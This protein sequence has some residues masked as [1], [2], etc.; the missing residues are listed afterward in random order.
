MRFHTVYFVTYSYL[1]SDSEQ[2][3]LQRFHIYILHSLHTAAA[4]TK[5]TEAM[6]A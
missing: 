5:R 6:S 2:E 3:A 1:Y 4:V